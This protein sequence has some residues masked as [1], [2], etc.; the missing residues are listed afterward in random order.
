MAAKRHQSGST[1]ARDARHL[2]ELSADL[3]IGLA[4]DSLLLAT[5][6]KVL[7]SCRV[8][9]C[10]RRRRA[11]SIPGYMVWAAI[12]YSGSASL[13]S[14]WVG[15]AL[16]AATPTATPARLNLRSLGRVNDTSPDHARRG[17][18]DEARRIEL[19]LKGVLRRCVFW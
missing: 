14:Y 15:K 12:V 6:I 19:D 8:P 5:F 18:P 17:E 16:I 10:P 2:T 7:W 3:G 13:L 9:S 11:I 1:H 4:Q